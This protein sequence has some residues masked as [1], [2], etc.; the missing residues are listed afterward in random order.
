MRTPQNP[1]V[2]GKVR[3]FVPQFHYAIMAVVLMGIC[4]LRALAQDHD[5]MMMTQEQ[6]TPEQKRQ[7]GLLLQRVRE[8]TE[9]FKDVGEA[10][11]EHYALTFGCVSGPDQGAMGLH[12][13]NFALVGSGVIDPAHPQIILYE[14]TPGGRPRLT[15]A[16]YLVDAA[17]W[18]SDP[19][20]TGPPELMGQLFH[21][22]EAPNRFHLPAFYTLH[23]WA[24][25]DNPSGAF[26][27]WNPNVS[28][29]SFVGET[30]ND[31]Q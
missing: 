26:A 20:H 8:A 9:R 3:R 21:Y 19:K 5:H 24:W 7:Q 16:D 25:K 30:N 22:F 23:V 31:P 6:L 15:G 17:Q 11:Y 4:P 2:A 14:P 18:D 28:C 13:V 29:A 10:I 12:Y 1:T 27:N